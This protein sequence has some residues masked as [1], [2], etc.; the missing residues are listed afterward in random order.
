[1]FMFDVETLDTESTTVI[2]S[3]ALCYFDVTKK[4]SFEQLVEDSVFVKFNVNEQR[5][6]MN[7][8][9]SK[10]TLQWWSE[11]S[12]HARK[13]SFTPS[14]EDVPA[15]LGIEILHRYVEQHDPKQQ[16]QFW[17]RGSLDQMCIDSLARSLGMDVIAP[18]WAW[19]DVRTAVDCLCGTSNGYADVD[20]E[21]FNRYNVVKHDPVHDCAL[22]AMMLMYGKEI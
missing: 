6:G 11:Q 5:D 21:G 1:M 20:F 12:D 17:A 16:C 3:A 13:K 14:E 22:D 9:M 8:T 2:L 4:P 10:D 7:R 18:Y 19:R 15:R